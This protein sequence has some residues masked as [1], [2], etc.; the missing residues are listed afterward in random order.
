MTADRTELR[1]E[2]ESALVEVLAHVHGDADLAYRIVD[3]PSSQRIA[4]A[5]DCG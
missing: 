1:R 3:D 5:T 2:I 4:P